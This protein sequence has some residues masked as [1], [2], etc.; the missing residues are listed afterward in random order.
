MIMIIIIF[1][2]KKPFKKKK[3]E[4]EWRR[5]EL[6]LSWQKFKRQTQSLC[7]PS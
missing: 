7:E 1:Y 2:E 5:V 3:K 4:E 6:F